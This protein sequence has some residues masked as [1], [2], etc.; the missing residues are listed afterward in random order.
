MTD[1][2]DRIFIVEDHP[3]MRE[4]IRDYLGAIPGLAICG[5]AQS[6]E[7]ALELLEEAAPDLVLVDTSL[8]RM[9]GIDFVTQARERWAGIRCLMLSG[10]GQE[11][12]VERALD[13]GASGYVLKGDPAELPR[14]IRHV[15]DEGERYL[16]PRLR[17]P[18]Q[19]PEGL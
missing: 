12:Y 13:A 3:L 10:H 15:L 18:G 6:G 9:S 1:R 16:S 7:E 2:D 11:N 17:M 8:A 5:E 19:A 14:A 4:V